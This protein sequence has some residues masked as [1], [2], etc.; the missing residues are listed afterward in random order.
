MPKYPVMP[1]PS[2]RIQEQARPIEY[3]STNVFKTHDAKLDSII[4]QLKSIDSHL[5]EIK[6]L[7]STIGMDLPKK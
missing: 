6:D 1:D 2:K 4:E 5:S 7:L 3:K